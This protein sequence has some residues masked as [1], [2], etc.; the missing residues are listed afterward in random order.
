VPPGTD[1]RPET[2][3]SAFNAPVPLEQDRQAVVRVVQP[4]AHARY[5]GTLTKIHGL[6]EPGDGR[7]SQRPCN[8]A[9]PFPTTL[10]VGVCPR[11]LT[12]P[13]MAAVPEGTA[14]S[15]PARSLLVRLDRLSLRLLH[16]IRG[17]QLL[18][19]EVEGQLVDLA[20]EGERHLVVLFLY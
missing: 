3:S 14:E 7:F 20:V 8:S 13:L 10:Q 16:L 19:L 2:P 9:G 5:D 15:I 11:R 12:D 6:G 18:M 4:G 17:K 1:F